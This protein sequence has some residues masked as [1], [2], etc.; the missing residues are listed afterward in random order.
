MLSFWIKSLHKHR[1][2]SGASSISHCLGVTNVVGGSKY[3]MFVRLSTV[4]LLRE[5][6]PVV[7]LSM[8]INLSCVICLAALRKG[9]PPRELELCPPWFIWLEGGRRVEIQV[10]SYTCLKNVSP[11]PYSLSLRSLLKGGAVILFIKPRPVDTSFTL[12]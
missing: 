11:L 9:E 12:V 3:S 4:L 7:V 10:I 6:E 1:I 2:G 5:D 8:L